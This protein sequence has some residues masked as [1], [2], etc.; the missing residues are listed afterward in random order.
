MDK[1]DFNYALPKRLIAQH[2][3][4]RR[5]AS[6]L[7]VV[8]AEPCSFLDRYFT[9]VVDLLEAGDL[10][11]LNNTRVI[12]AR[13]GGTKM[14]GGKIE[15][16][17][18]R[19]RSNN[20]I[21]AQIRSNRP[22]RKGTWLSFSEGYNCQVMGRESDLYVLQIP[23]K[24]DLEKMLLAIGEM[25]LP[26]YINRSADSSDSERYQ[27]VF[28]SK[29]GAVAA[30]TAGLHFDEGLIK[31]LVDKGVEIVWICL[32]VGS[33]TFQPIRSECLEDH[34]MHSEYLEVPSETVERV[35]LAKNSGKRVIAVGTTVVRAL[36]SAALNGNISSY[37]GETDL[38]IKPGFQFRVV[39]VMVTN[40]HL[41]ESTLLVLV[42]SFAGTKRMLDAYEHAVAEDYRFFSYGDAMF[43]EISAR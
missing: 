29:P 3:L 42:C 23:A 33:G 35:K 9:D 18:E 7:L 37:C 26:P 32:H 36:E 21:L 12:P 6:R 5:S 34:V 17:I 10:L 41:P 11:V 31:K 4:S 43:I 28:A 38:F 24:I 27:T 40:F 25:P 16:L 15:I 8:K 13:I 1:A 20:E 39:D 2:P 30:P 19:I 22:I 14:T